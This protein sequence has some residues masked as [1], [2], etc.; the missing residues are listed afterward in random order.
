MALLAPHFLQNPATWIANSSH[1]K[2]FPT[3]FLLWACKDQ[4]FHFYRKPFKLFGEHSWTFAIVW[5]T[6]AFQLTSCSRSQRGNL[7]GIIFALILL[8]QKG[9]GATCAADPS[10][11]Q[12]TEFEG[13]SSRLSLYPQ[14]AGP[15]FKTCG[16][17]FCFSPVYLA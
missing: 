6:F 13:T 8:H 15:V 12:R 4:T 14:A 17:W 3:K 11:A 9:G 1:L 5:D 16:L 7:L 10:N 2:G